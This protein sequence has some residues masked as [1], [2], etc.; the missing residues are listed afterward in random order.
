MSQ[1]SGSNKQPGKRRATSQSAATAPGYAGKRTKTGNSAGFRFEG[2]L[3]KSHPEF[4]GAVRAHVIAPGRLLI[5]AE[6]APTQEAD[7]VIDAFLALLTQDMIDHPHRI[8]PLDPE[9]WN[10]MASLTQGV[11]ATMDGDLGDETLI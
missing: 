8:Q 10:E 3:F 11:S 2:A 9:R 4:S 5:T 6:P 7:P 1:T